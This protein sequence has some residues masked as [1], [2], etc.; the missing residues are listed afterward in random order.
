MSTFLELVLENLSELGDVRAR[1][2]FGGHGLYAGD[3]FFGIVYEDRLYFKTDDATRGW[4]EGKGMSAFQP[5]PRQ[6][7]KNYLEV[8]PDQLE[9]P[10]LLVERALEAIGVAR[11]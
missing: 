5:N 1:S 3:A 11:D 9:A 4:Y 2:M 6:R 10:D 7:L 8:P